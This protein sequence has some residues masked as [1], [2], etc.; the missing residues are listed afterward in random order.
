MAGFHGVVDDREERHASRV[1]AQRARAHAAGLEAMRLEQ[2]QFEVVPATL[3]PDGEEYSVDAL[4]D[5]LG[6]R[7]FRSRIGHETLSTGSIGS[8]RP[9]REQAFQ[10]IL[11]QHLELPVDRNSRQP[12]IAR[13]LQSF[14]EERAVALGRQHMR[15][16]VVAF[17]ALCVGQDDLPGSQRTELRPQPPHH[18]WPRKRKQ[19]VDPGAGWD[20][21]VK[22]AAQSDGAKGDRFHG[23]HT[24][25]AID[26]ADA[27]VM[28]GRDLENVQQVPATRAP[29]TRTASS[30]SLADF[31]WLEKNE[32]HDLVFIM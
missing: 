29:K 32:I 27:N 18:F 2:G 31:T 15:V 19:Q 22:R 4:A 12:C 28:S 7:F 16:E 10:V 8:T 6:R 17:H 13:L 20:H 14:H 3:R 25:G 9:A 5:H 26:D 11:D 21:R 23:S 1:G 30:A 24:A